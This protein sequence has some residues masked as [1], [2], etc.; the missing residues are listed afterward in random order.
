MTRE[1]RSGKRYWKG[2]L[3]CN[4]VKYLVV[5]YFGKTDEGN[6]F[7]FGDK[8]EADATFKYYDEFT[9]AVLVEFY[10]C[11][12][13]RAAQKGDDKKHSSKNAELAHRSEDQANMP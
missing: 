7:F 12:L 13:E 4:M 3:R 1:L 6:V 9:D 2:C 8:I 10:I 11:H 5:V